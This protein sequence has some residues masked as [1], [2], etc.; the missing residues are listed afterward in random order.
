VPVRSGSSS[1]PNQGPYSKV[2]TSYRLAESPEERWSE[3]GERKAELLVPA[4][5]EA[6][7]NLRNPKILHMLG[8]TSVLAFGMQP[9]VRF[10]PSSNDGCRL[11]IC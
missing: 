3:S 8:I 9:S 6:G 2:L 11:D 1:W 7:Q 5:S 4:E 10:E